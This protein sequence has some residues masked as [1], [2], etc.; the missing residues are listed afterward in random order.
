MKHRNFRQNQWR[1]YLKHLAKWLLYCFA[2]MMLALAAIMVASG[3][4]V[5]AAA[6][7]NQ[8]EE[9]YAPQRVCAAIGGENAGHFYASNGRLVCTNKHGRRLSKQP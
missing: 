2:L 7:L 4:K 1:R 3:A 6:A 5:I 9:Q 8:A